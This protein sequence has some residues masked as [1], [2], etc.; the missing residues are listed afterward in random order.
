[1]PT[2]V[3]LAFYHLT[4]IPGREFK[5]SKVPPPETLSDPSDSEMTGPVIVNCIFR[6]GLTEEH[7]G[8]RANAPGGLLLGRLFYY[9]IFDYNARYHDHPILIAEDV[10]SNFKWSFFTT[11]S[12]FSGRTHLDPELTVA[13]NSIKENSSRTCER[14][15]SQNIFTISHAKG[16]V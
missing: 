15:I 7:S 12:V 3:A 11:R 14:Q 5:E 16:A 1:V 9:F 4:D 8:F 13:E 6:K 10:N 2:F